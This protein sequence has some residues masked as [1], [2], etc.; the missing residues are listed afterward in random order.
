MIESTEVHTFFIVNGGITLQRR[1]IPS[2]TTRRAIP[3]S[4]RHVEVG[5]RD[6]PPL[7]AVPP[8]HADAAPPSCGTA[9]RRGRPPSCHRTVRTSRCCTVMS[10]G[11]SLNDD[12]LD[13]L[14]R[15][16]AR[17]TPVPS[18]RW[19]WNAGSRERGER[20]HVARL[21]QGEDFATSLSPIALGSF[22]FGADAADA[23]ADRSQRAR[24]PQWPARP[25]SERGATATDPGTSRSRFHGGE[26]YG[27]FRGSTYC[28]TTPVISGSLVT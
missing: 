22:S 17:L 18:A 4:R 28:S 26:G 12:T 9:C 10:S 14:A 15:Y 2:P 24:S 1:G 6:Q 5:V 20:L 7:T 11:P 23:G 16:S 25:A 27:P 19:S 13:G 8:E 3:G 21:Q